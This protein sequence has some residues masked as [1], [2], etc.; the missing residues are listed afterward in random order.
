MQ[1]D[2][3]DQGPSPS[4]SPRVVVIFLKKMKLIK[5][6]TIRIPVFHIHIV[7]VPQ[8]GATLRSGIDHKTDAA[9]ACSVHELKLRRDAS[10][11]SLTWK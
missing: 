8:Q 7:N 6:Q 5:R 3:H 9:A 4:R 1:R 10:W 2:R 11:P